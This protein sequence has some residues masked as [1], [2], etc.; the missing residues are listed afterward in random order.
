MLR[1]SIYAAYAGVPLEI[2]VKRIENRTCNK[3]RSWQKKYVYRDCIT[4]RYQGSGNHIVHYIREPFIV[5]KGKH[6][7]TIGGGL[8]TVCSH[9]LNI[10][11]SS[12]SAW[13]DSKLASAM[14]VVHEIFHQ[15]GANHSDV[16]DN[17]MLPVLPQ[18]AI[19][20]KGGLYIAPETKEQIKECLNSA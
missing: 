12:V 14:V 3:Y 5:G 16:P 10:P 8:A 6:R 17:I 15:L 7:G 2:N 4:K 9:R 13:S 20:Q 11:T 1:V 18:Q 19:Q